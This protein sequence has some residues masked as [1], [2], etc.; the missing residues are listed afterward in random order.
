MVH[1]AMRERESVMESAPTYDEQLLNDVLLLSLWAEA[2][3][4]MGSDTE[5]VGDRFK[6]MKLAFFAAYDLYTTKVK[7]LSLT[8][9]RWRRGPMSKEIYAAW[10]HLTELGFMA[11]DE[12]FG[13]T[14]R[15]MELAAG[16]SDEVLALEPNEPI[17]SAFRLTAESWGPL[18]TDEIKARIY[19]VYCLTTQSTRRRPI[20]S[21]AMGERF[22]EPLDESQADTLIVV[23]PAWQETLELALNKRA[24]VDLRAGIEDMYRGRVCS[25]WNP[26]AAAV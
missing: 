4:A 18:T 3:K 24:S 23:P 6:L 22:T 14:E 26:F 13:V 8:F 7:A 17:C 9:F 21:I 5:T 19:D 10:E 2:Q 25:G 16:F 20:R 11:E 1:F 12:E 15:G